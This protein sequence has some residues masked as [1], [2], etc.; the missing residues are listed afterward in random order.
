MAKV[1][2]ALSAIAIIC[3]LSS[4]IYNIIKAP[5]PDRKKMIF[6]SLRDVSHVIFIVIIPFCFKYGDDICK[7][8]ALLTTRLNI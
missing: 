2:L 3:Y 5:K 8:V 6:N 7:L 1:I 4:V